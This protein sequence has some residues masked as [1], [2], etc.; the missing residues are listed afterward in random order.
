MEGAGGIVTALDVEPD[1]L[2]E[3]QR[4]LSTSVFG[5]DDAKEGAL[6]F[7]EKREPNWTGH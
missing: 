2:W 5:S 1:D 7:I 3:L 4:E 6:A